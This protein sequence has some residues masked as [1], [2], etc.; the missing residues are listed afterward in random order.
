LLCFWRFPHE[1]FTTALH[2]II[3]K[4]WIFL[5]ATCALVNLQAQ[6]GDKAG[7]EQPIPAAAKE[8]PPAP[9]LSP[10]DAL[11]SFKI[12]PGFRIEVVA[13]DPM[14]QSPVQIQ[15][16]GNGRM[17]V[18]EMRG[19][20]RNVDGLH[21]EEPVGRVSLLTDTNGD[22]VM[23]NSVVFADGLVMP[24]AI[25]LVRGGLL[26]AE[27]PHL[28][29]FRDADGDGK[30]EEKEEVSN[31]YGNQKNPEHNANGLLWARDNWIYSAN[32]TVRYRNLDGDWQKD[33]TTF[34]GQWGISQDDYGRLFFNSNSDPLR[35]D[36]VPSQYLLR[37]PNFKNPLGDNVQ[38]EKSM[39]VFP[40]RVNP[41]VNRGYQ[42]GQL[43][44]DGTLAT[45]TGAC[46]PVIYRG[47]MF[48]DQFYGA[49]FLCEPTGN[50]IRCEFLH[51]ENGFITATNAFPK[52]EFL[53]SS[54]ER[55]RPVNLCNGPDGALYVVDMYQ[56]LL[57]HRIYLTTYLRNQYLSRGLEKPINMGRIYRIVPENVKKTAPVKLEDA[58]S[59]ELVAKLSD[60]NG[61]V[62]DTAQRLLI[63]KR[64]SRAVKPLRE[65][66]AKGEFP[67]ALHAFWVLHATDQLTP[68]TIQAGLRSSDSKVRATAVR[69]GENYLKVEGKNETQ[70]ALFAMAKDP[71]VDAKLQ[72]MFSLGESKSPE[73]EQVMLQ[74]LDQNVDNALIRDAAITGLAGREQK[75]IKQLLAQSSWNEKTPARAY[76][77]R[78]L[79]DCIAESRESSR[80][81]QLLDFAAN[82]SQ[83]W[84]KIALL[85]GIEKLIPPRGKSKTVAHAKPIRFGAEPAALAQLAKS[86]NSEVKKK[87]AALDEVL[88]WPG[89]AGY[90][91]EAVTPLTEQEKAR[92][93]AGKTQ[94]T[95]ICGACHQLNGQGLEG[96]APPLVDSDWVI[97]T[98]E[99]LTRIVLNGIRGKIN[100]KGKT[101]ELEMPPLN[102]L[103]DEDIASLLTYIRR[104]WGH[105][106]SPIAPD[107]VKKIRAETAGRQEAW[108][109][110]E[111]LKIGK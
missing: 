12:Q 47:E 67:A 43:R 59:V 56:G 29:F 24:R 16:D 42:K 104:D 68:A 75:F 107:F 49:A 4:F 18:L 79:A 70:A 7:E 94:Y 65:V 95:V 99:R 44:P 81:G 76:V 22:G 92:F 93:E 19:F 108:T 83:E 25:A 37:N 80:V 64:D 72:L 87:L 77:I 23:D 102:I 110:T 91:E 66:T 86:N 38:L 101:W 73:A 89:K 54:D 103:G 62:R 40:S 20:M 50:L 48:P 85:E 21:E 17:Y 55:F 71:S 78:T 105:T 39:A 27:P 74:L 82:A 51:E 53:T 3:M 13:S 46:G 1:H 31:D 61:W 36:L 5:F 10:E 30:A 63:E 6:N 84:Q 33:V 34:R 96:L 98:P 111:L 28:W 9:P 41:G 2:L 100:V 26:V 11:K 109:E 35:G 69:M 90:H 97:G 45:F 14:V 88:V 52:T 106:A 58:S 15:F 57:Q 60:R 8:A 32:H